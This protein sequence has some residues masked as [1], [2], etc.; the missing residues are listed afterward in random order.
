MVMLSSLLCRGLSDS[1]G[2]KAELVDLTVDLAAGDYPPVTRLLVGQ[3]GRPMSALQWEAVRIG[4]R[5]SGGELLIVSNL[6]A[7]EP[8]STEPLEKAVLLKRDV[9]DSLVL[10]LENGH[11]T[12][13]NDLWLEPEEGR[14]LLRAADVSPWAVLRRLGRGLLGRG[15]DRNLL[16]WKHVEF[17]RGDPQAARAGRDYHRRVAHLPPAEIARLADA[18]PYLHAAELLSLIPDPVGA[19]VLEAMTPERQIQVFEE[20]DDD[21]AI[22][23]LAL[24]APDIVADLLGRV[25][26]SLAQR[27]LNQLPS[28]QRE[29]VVELLR[30]PEDTAGGIMTNDVIVAPAS[31]T[32][33]EARARL[34]EQ[35]RAPD[36]VYYVYVVG[37][38]DTRQL[39]GVLSLRDL[40]V[41]DDDR[42]LKEIMNPNLMRIDPLEPAVEAARRVADNHFAALP[43]VARDGRLLGAVTVDAAT[44]QLA[45]AGWREQAPRVFS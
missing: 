31:L 35:L 22:R 39:L 41:A 20:L 42:R 27:H 10:D 37:D 44:A 15:A 25:E 4:D 19:D 45:P 9:L 21:Q 26:P 36:F 28:L 23:L 1:A 24:M 43:V 2:R 17:L 13:A 40:L 14:L 30:Y 3:S 8:T 5:H 34:R 33:K 11:A 18:M 16:D 38:E 6:S 7:A 12:R 32:A 29:R